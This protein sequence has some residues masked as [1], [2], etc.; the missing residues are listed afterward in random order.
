[1]MLLLRCEQLAREVED[2]LRR[3]GVAASSA[4]AGRRGRVGEGSQLRH[5]R[6]GSHRPVVWGS[7]NE[8]EP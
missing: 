3:G 7:H 6:R 5:G 4:A 1:M 2:V 8:L